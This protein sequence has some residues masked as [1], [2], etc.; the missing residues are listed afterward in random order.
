MSGVTCLMYESYDE[1]VWHLFFGCNYAEEVWQEEG[2]WKILQGLQVQK[3][4][5][6]AMIFCCIWRRCNE[7]T[8][9]NHKKLV[10]AAVQMAKVVLIEWQQLHIKH[11]A[12]NAGKNVKWTKGATGEHNSSVNAAIFKANGFDTG[13][14][15]RNNRRIHKTSG[16]WCYWR[17]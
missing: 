13:M 11:S 14:C 9:E 2:I 1:N 4:K 5:V 8:W 12:P 10:T 6:F 7:N 16:G 3:H 15:I 17:S